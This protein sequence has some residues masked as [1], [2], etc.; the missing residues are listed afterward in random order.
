MP[1]KVRLFALEAVDDDSDGGLLHHRG[2]YRAPGAGAVR[3]SA[4]GDTAKRCSGS[5]RAEGDGDDGQSLVPPQP[6]M[7]SYGQVVKSFFEDKVGHC[8]DEDEALEGDAVDVCGDC[9]RGLPGDGVYFP[10]DGKLR[11]SDGVPAVVSEKVEVYTSLVS[12]EFLLRPHSDGVIDRVQQPTSTDPTSCPVQLSKSQKTNAKKKKKRHQKHQLHDD[13]GDAEDSKVGVEDTCLQLD[14]PVRVLQPVEEQQQLE[15]KPLDTALDS[16]PDC[17]KFLGAIRQPE[18]HSLVQVNSHDVSVD[19]QPTHSR[20]EHTESEK[21]RFK[22]GKGRGS[23]SQGCSMAVAAAATGLLERALDGSQRDSDLAGLREGMSRQ[24]QDRV[25]AVL[26]DPRAG[27]SRHIAS[28][29]A[30]GLDNSAASD[31]GVR[32]LQ[33]QLRLRVAKGVGKKSKE[34]S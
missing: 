25:L 9:D 11:S 29:L 21:P 23:D 13:H 7:P 15:A 3:A 24:L 34:L 31:A 2:R 26:D 4:H 5:A 14:N 17:A 1:G 12:E 6:W 33:E 16:L 30:S 18:D 32:R 27:D 22:A 28:L 20:T 19:V 8:A 10:D